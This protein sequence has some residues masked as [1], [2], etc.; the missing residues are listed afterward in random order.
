MTAVHASQVA[1]Y[2]TCPR[3][4]YYQYVLGLV[5]KAE[6]PKLFIG[7]GV[8]EGL[9]AYYACGFDRGK[10]L[11]AYDAWAN[12]A[13]KELENAAELAEEVKFGFSLVE[14]Y[15]DFAAANDDFVPV[16]FDGVPAIEQP[17]SVPV[18]DPDMNPVPDLTH[19]G[20][21]DGVVR[22][23]HGRLWLLEHKTASSFPREVVLR[24][25]EQAGL[26]LLAA[27]QLFREPPVGVI[28]NVI[29]K[30][31]PK[32]A[33]A[34]VVRRYHVLRSPKEL[35]F[36]RLR[37][38]HTCR[39]MLADELYLPSPG[40]HCGWKCAYTRLCVC[41]HEGVDNTPLVEAFYIRTEDGRRETDWILF[42]DE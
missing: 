18:W 5:P 6:S 36:L 34:D 17:F 25:D 13:L 40:F 2:R 35:E 19:E 16:T 12:E 7:R 4:Y 8:H 23:R 38:Y 9:A 30:T 41:D 3:M 10:A 32:R 26:Y 28:Y 24:L 27:T 29:R 15:C 39:I 11:A 22:D 31:N 33:R 20:R 21:F 42:T 37:F 14:A 1:S